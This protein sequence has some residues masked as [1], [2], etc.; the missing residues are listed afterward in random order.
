MLSAEAGVDISSTI[1]YPTPNA[2]A[3]AL[4]PAE[5]RDNP[6]IFPSEAQLEKCPF[7][8]RASA[9]QQQAF[10]EIFA[11]VRMIAGR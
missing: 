10:D 1:M 4:M 6:V 9:A 7:G 8:R 5:Y 3:R 2:A 11:R